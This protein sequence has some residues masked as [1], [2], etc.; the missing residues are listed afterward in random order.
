MKNVPRIC[1]SFIFLCVLLCLPAAVYSYQFEPITQDFTAFG[2]DAVKTFRVINNADGDL[3]AMKI[4][5]T[6]RS[7]D[8]N[9][10]EIRTDASDSFFVYPEQFLVQPG[11]TQSIR[12][13]WIGE[14]KVETEKAFRIIVQQLPV[15]MEKTDAVAMLVNYEGTLYVLPEKLRVELN[16]LSVSRIIDADSNEPLLQIELENSG[17]T[18]NIITDP[19]LA[20]TSYKGLGLLQDSILLSGEQLVGFADT[21]ILA[22]HTR[23]YHVPWP[24]DLKDGNLQGVLSMKPRR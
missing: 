16:L 1:K 9:G 8:V 13:Q 15:Q 21:N 23:I 17:N 20:I 6:H 7:M 10:N 4:S 5:V 3:I 19:E 14:K 24:E 2:F 22:E 12:V 18:H 11:A